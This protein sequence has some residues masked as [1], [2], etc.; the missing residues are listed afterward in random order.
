MNTAW[1][2]IGGWLIASIIIGIVAG[3][4][5]DRMGDGS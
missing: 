1:L 4:L 2:I 5:I 3:K